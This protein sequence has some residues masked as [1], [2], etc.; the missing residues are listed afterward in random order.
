MMLLIGDRS[1]ALNATFNKEYNKMSAAIEIIE[2]TLIRS[3]RNQLNETFEIR[4]KLVVACF[5][6]SVS[7]LFVSPQ[8]VTMRESNRLVFTSLVDGPVSFSLDQR[9]QQRGHI[10]W[11]ERERP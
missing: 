4:T 6:L 8:Q 5:S 3:L 1:R 7:F 9:R 2:A 11:Q 10:G